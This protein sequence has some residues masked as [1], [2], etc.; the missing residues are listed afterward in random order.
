MAVFVEGSSLLSQFDEC[1][2]S[3][4]RHAMMQSYEYK[5]GYDMGT[6]YK[7]FFFLKLRIQYV[8]DICINKFL[9]ILYLYFVNIYFIYC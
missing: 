7:H 5:Y 4:V 9:N 2:F 8:R 3:V 1:D 6:G